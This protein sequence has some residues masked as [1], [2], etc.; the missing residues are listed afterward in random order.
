VKIEIRNL[1]SIISSTIE[2][3]S[4]ITII[5]GRN[6]A[7][8]SSQLLPVQHALTGQ[9]PSTPAER[10]EMI[11]EGHAS[12]VIK[13]T[14]GGELLYECTYPECKPTSTG[15]PAAGIYAAGLVRFCE[16]KP[17]VI[18]EYL[19]TLLKTE[20][21]IADLGKAMKERE[22]VK[23]MSLEEA[24]LYVKTVWDNIQRKGW[25]GAWEAYK[26][27]GAQ[28]KRD[29]KATTGETYGSDKGGKWS[30]QGWDDTLYSQSENS[31]RAQLTEAESWLEGL[32]KVEAVESAELERLEKEIADISEVAQKRDAAIIKADELEEKL[33]EANDRLKKLPRPAAQVETFDCWSCGAHIDKR[34]KE[35]PPEAQTKEELAAIQAALESAQKECDEL[36]N[37]YALAREAALMYR[38]QFY[39]KDN[40]RTKLKE[41]KARPKT[42]APSADEIEAQRTKINA[43]R[44]RLEAY[45]K[46]ITA[47]AAHKNVQQNQLLIDLLEPDGWRRG[48]SSAA[49]H[50]LNEKYLA[51]FSE[52]LGCPVIEISS[53]LNI[54]WG[55]RSYRRCSPGEKWLINA[56]FQI[57]LAFIGGA[58]LMVFDEAGILD[59]TYAQKFFTLLSQ[60]PI[61]SLVALTRGRNRVPN[62]RD[63]AAAYWAENHSIER[64][65]FTAVAK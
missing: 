7:G 52:A 64:V 63:A 56:V 38:S 1:G 41:L 25:D 33:K 14:D 26:E 45:N 49:L 18:S 30:P 28:W 2:L 55:G 31:L 40:Q 53:D 44:L 5:S 51:P 48:F 65:D 15:R 20:P 23:G 34:T 47:D 60:Q 58:D 27:R 54:T 9:F 36:G 12:G 46:K 42:D 13:I 16:E 29:W 22:I 57:A 21:T 59:P 10:K 8:K 6:G 43:C 62:L 35:K 11:R 50:E 61:P 32:L 4:K 39:T 17:K 24:K 3:H 19:Q 37:E